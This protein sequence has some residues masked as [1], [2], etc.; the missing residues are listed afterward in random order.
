MRNKIKG[1]YEAL[2]I[3][4]GL[5]VIVVLIYFNKRKQNARKPRMGCRLFFTFAGI[6]L[7]KVGEFDTSATLIVLNHQSVADILCLEGFHP[8]NICWIAKKEL[9]EIPF[10]GYALKGPEMILIDRE[11]KRGLTFLLKSAKEKL[12][13]NRPLVIFPEGTRSKGGEKFLTFK[14]GAK[15]LAEKFQLKVQPIVLIN[16]RKVYNTSPLE[17][18]SNTARMVIM[19]SFYPQDLGE[20]WQ[21]RWYEKLK[22]DM[23]KTYLQ[24]YHEL[25]P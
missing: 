16:T 11:D 23:H 19:D 7:Q 1:I 12:A 4:I 20:G 17:S 8:Q 21:E 15:I 5:A 6:E 25:N 3:S 13:Q 10:Y 9:G 22:E 2:L 24:H 18:T 14:P